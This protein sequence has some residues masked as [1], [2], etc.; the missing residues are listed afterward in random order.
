MRRYRLYE[1]ECNR[2]GTTALALDDWFNQ[3]EKP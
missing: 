2:A 1:Y 3:K